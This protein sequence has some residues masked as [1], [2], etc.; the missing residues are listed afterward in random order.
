MNKKY[1]L[2]I[3][4]SFYFISHYRKFKTNNNCMNKESDNVKEFYSYSFN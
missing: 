4:Y 3:F 2:L 1:I